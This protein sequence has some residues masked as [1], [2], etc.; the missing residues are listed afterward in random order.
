MKLLII[1]GADNTGKDTLI[2]ALSESNPNVI[3]R[4][5]SY[6]VGDTNEEKTLHQVSTFISEFSLYNKLKNLEHLEGTLMIW[7]RSHIGEMVYGKIYRNSSPDNWVMQLEELSGIANDPDVYLVYLHGDP[8][9]LA[10][11]DD[12]LS[13]SADMSDKIFEQYMFAEAV[14]KSAIKNLLTLKINSGDSYVDQSTIIDN[15]LEFIY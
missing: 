13:Y 5:W 15:V 14:D 1:E 10:S 7:N 12:G 8:E 3:K 2:N 6:P 4:H 11:V 9:F